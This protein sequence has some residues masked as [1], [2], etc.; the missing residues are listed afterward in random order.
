MSFGCLFDPFWM[1]LGHLDVSGTNF[2]I[3]LIFNDVG[4]VSAAES[5]CLFDTILVLL[6]TCWRYFVC[7]FVL[8]RTLLTFCSF[9]IHFGGFLGCLGTLEIGLKR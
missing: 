2:Y 5:W 6:T 1:L 9:R 8:L 3:F 7:I 4:N